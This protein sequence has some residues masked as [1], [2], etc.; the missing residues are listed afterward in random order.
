MLFITLTLSACKKET[1]IPQQEAS[2]ALSEQL[3]YDN[4]AKPNVADVQ[5]N[6]PITIKTFIENNFTKTTIHTYQVKTVPV[7]GKKYEVKLNNGVELEFNEA[8]E[9]IEIQ[10]PAGVAS[11]FVV[12]PIQE[13]VKSKYASTFITGIEKEKNIVKIEL[14]NDVDLVFDAGG[15]FLR[16]D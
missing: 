7:I 9:W 2:T 3:G 8:G 10:D 13:Y 14:A 6:L 5:N 16:I 1:V 11:K 12:Q 4:V 15:K